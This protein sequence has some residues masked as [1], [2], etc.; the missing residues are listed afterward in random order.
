[1]LTKL[2]PAIWI[3]RVSRRGT[4]TEL[5]IFPHWTSNAVY[6]CKINAIK[7]KRFENSNC[8]QSIH[9]SIHFLYHTSFVSNLFCFL[10]VCRFVCLSVCPCLYLCLSLCPYICPFVSDLLY[11]WLKWMDTFDTICDVHTYILP[12]HLDICIMYSGYVLGGG[13]RV[14]N[15]PLTTQKQESTYY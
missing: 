2:S 12:I 9:A 10:A 14:L 7:S 5:T 4:D 13:N 8:Y 15:G 11:L 1:M 3:C 6:I